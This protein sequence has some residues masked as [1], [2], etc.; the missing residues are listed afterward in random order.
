M[1]TLPNYDDWKLNNDLDDDIEEEQFEDNE[2]E[3]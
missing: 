1:E 3:R 2:G